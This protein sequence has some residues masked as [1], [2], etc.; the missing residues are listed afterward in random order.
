ME[1]KGK[2]KKRGEEENGGSRPPFVYHFVSAIMP[3][4]C[5]VSPFISEKPPPRGCRHCWPNHVKYC[6]C[7][8]VFSL[9]L[10]IRRIKPL[11]RAPIVFEF[12]VKEVPYVSLC[13]P[14]FLTLQ[15]LMFWMTYK[16]Q[17]MKCILLFMWVFYSCS[18]IRYECY[19][20]FY[21][22]V[23]QDSSYFKSDY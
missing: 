6:V 20:L 1:E 17:G 23:A 15:K 2:R 9:K 18:R 8:R 13:Y 11:S 12:A 19:S 7:C 21:D 22:K 16:P 4:M 14:S 5:I 10:V 3:F